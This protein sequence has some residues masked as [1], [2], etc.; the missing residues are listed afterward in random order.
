MAD[1]RAIEDTL[2]YL[3]EVGYSKATAQA[4]DWDNIGAL[5][6]EPLGGPDTESARNETLKTVFRDALEQMSNRIRDYAGAAAREHADLLSA[7]TSNLMQRLLDDR[8]AQLAD[9]KQRHSNRITKEEA[10]NLFEQLDGDL[11]GLSGDAVAMLKH[12]LDDPNDPLPWWKR[13]S[14]DIQLAFANALISAIVSAAVA[15]AI[16]KI[17]GPTP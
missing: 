11:I 3:A 7:S 4:A 16:T 6:H 5:R 2:K 10:D 17:G 13:H 8:R 12:K 9:P 1:R 15:F 14:K